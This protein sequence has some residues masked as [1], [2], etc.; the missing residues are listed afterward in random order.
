MVNTLG[1]RDALQR[2]PVACQHGL[3]DSPII[4]VRNTGDQVFYG[5][6]GLL[7]VD[8]R[9]WHQVRGHYRVPVLRQPEPFNGDLQSAPELGDSAANFHYFTLVGCADGTRVVPDLGV[10]AAGPVGKGG[11]QKG[12]SAAG[13]FGPGTLE[14]VEALHLVPGG[15]VFDVLV[16]FHMYSFHCPLVC[17]HRPAQASPLSPPV[18]SN[19]RCTAASPH[20][21]SG[22]TPPR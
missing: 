18:S 4:R 17:S 7:R 5:R 15:H 21:R 2:L 12:L 20:H 19:R 8:G 10:D 6:H 11:V 9:H 1:R 22:S 14:D 16:V 13:H 3:A